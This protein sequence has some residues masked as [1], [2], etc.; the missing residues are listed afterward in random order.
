MQ[1]L[2]L[3]EASIGRKKEN[4]PQPEMGKWPKNGPPPQKVTPNPIF[5][6]IFWS[7]L[8]ISGRGPFSLFFLVDFLSFSVFGP[9]PFYTRPPYSAVFEHWCFNMQECCGC[10]KLLN[11]ISDFSWERQVL[12]TPGFWKRSTW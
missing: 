12:K 6:G 10:L 4:G 1:A 3:W 2:A 7:F 5:G 9:F 11:E 8:P